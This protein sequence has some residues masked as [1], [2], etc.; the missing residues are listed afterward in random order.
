MY[1]SILFKATQPTTG[2]ITSYC[3]IDPGIRYSRILCSLEKKDSNQFDFTYKYI[4][5]RIFSLFS[6]CSC[7]CCTKCLSTKSMVK[8]D[9]FSLKISNIDFLVKMVVHVIF[10]KVHSVVH[11]QLV[12]AVSAVKLT[13]LLQ[14]H[15]T[16]TNVSM[17][18]H[19][20]LLDST[21]INAPAQLVS[22]VLDAKSVF[23]NQTHVYT[24][25]SA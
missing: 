20:K 17:V 14:T 16:Q 4:Y 7:C 18:V 9:A 1:Y 22:T 2:C 24:V 8:K 12:S 6:C 19:A 5:I 23:A 25:V 13:W 21:P 15:V 10:V 3:Q 11:V